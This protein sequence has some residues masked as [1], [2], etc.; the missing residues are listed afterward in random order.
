MKITVKKGDALKQKSPC[1]VLGVFAGKLKSEQLAGL[2]QQV[3]GALHRAIHSKEFTAAKGEFLLLH[4]GAETVAERI[5]L[6]GLGKEAT[7]SLRALRQLSSEATQ[8]LAKKQLGIF[9]LALPQIQL[10]K[11][12]KNDQIQAIAEGVLL[13]D[14]HYDRYLPQDRPGQPI[15]RQIAVV[16]VIS[17]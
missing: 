10:K 9:L 3:A 11:T 5:L 8:Y 13:A 14:Y 15:L 17:Q 4:G 6:V 12:D 7:F 2:D 1:L 16:V